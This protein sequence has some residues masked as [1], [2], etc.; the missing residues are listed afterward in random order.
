M[1]DC[2]KHWDWIAEILTNDNRH[3]SFKLPPKALNML[4]LWKQP[5]GASRGVVV[6]T[7]AR[8]WGSKLKATPLNKCRATC[9]VVE[10]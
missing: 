9:S 5:V 10:A 1:K 8:L 3:I 7:V 4:V 2:H 6:C